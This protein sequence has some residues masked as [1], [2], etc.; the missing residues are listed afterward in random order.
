[1]KKKSKYIALA[2]VLVFLLYNSFYFRNLK[3]KR[4]EGAQNNFDAE[5]YA[6]NFWDKLS[7]KLDETAD[8]K[9]FLT[10]FRQDSKKAIEK[11]STKAKH[12]SST[13]FFLLQGEGRLISTTKE[14][15]LICLTESEAKPDILIPTGLVFGAAIRNASGLVDSDDF[16]DSMNYNKVSEEID[17]IVMKQVIPAFKDKAKEGSIVHFIGAAEVFEDNPQINPLRVIP[18]RLEF[19]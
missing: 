9:Q 1:M 18:I 3:E 11:Y 17:N 2:A 19:K 8:A 7:K 4:A 10:L 15:V 16:P 13:H 5:Q 14:G 12:V 6:R